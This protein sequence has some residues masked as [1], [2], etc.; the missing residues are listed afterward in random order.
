MKRISN[1]VFLCPMPMTIVSTEVDGRVNHLAVGWITRAN[2]NPP[3]IAM[4]LNRGHHSNSGIRACRELGVSVPSCE[5]AAVVD[6][7]GL[8]S[9]AR[10]DKSNLFE[11]F[12]GGLAHAP[13]IVGFPLTF[14]CRLVQTVD[15]P[16]HDL[17]IAEIVEAYGD[18][19]IL[20]DDHPDV[21]KMH[22]F[23]LTMPDNRYWTVGECI[24]GAWSMGK[25]HA[26]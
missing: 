12:R 15:L 5:H 1:N 2:G 7:A 10:T 22:P 14:A 17:F 3:M 21:E 16:T 24:G 26:V 25:G 20:T 6:Y 4:G 18:E 13:M 9:G 8:V 11:V 23:T 19:A